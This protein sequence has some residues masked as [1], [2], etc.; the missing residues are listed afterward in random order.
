MNA[1]E[2]AVAIHAT[3][4]SSGRV[5][6]QLGGPRKAPTS[7]EG[8]TA[9][10][11]IRA[12]GYVV[13]KGALRT[14]RQKVVRSEVERIASSEGRKSGRNR[15]E[16]RKTVRPYGLLG[17][18]R[19]FDELVIHERVVELLDALLLPNYLLTASQVFCFFVFFQRSSF[20]T[21]FFQAIH[22]HLLCFKSFHFEISLF[23]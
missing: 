5:L 9:L 11:A 3:L 6:G 1:K 12:H 19:A 14:D 4:D 13:L 10:S 17:K 8:K 15:F 23:F 2:Q 21:C 18:S 7:E 20:S 16:G 22:S